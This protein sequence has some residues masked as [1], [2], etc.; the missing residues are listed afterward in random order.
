MSEPSSATPDGTA[1]PPK[2]QSA[3]K[4]AAEQASAEIAELAALSLPDVL[5][6][7]DSTATGLGAAD[8]A[9]RLKSVGPNRIDTAKRKHLLFAFIERLGNPL[10]AILLFAAA[11]SALT[12]DVASFV[13]IA[14]IVLISIVLDVTQERQAGNAAER[15]REE[16][17]LSVKAFRDG[18]PIDIPAAEVVPGDIVLLA[19]G[20]LVPADSRLIESRDLYVDEALLTGEPYPAEK[21]A[22]PTGGE[23]P[24]ESALPQNLVFMGSSVVSGTGK[25]LVLATGRK[26]QLGSI[27]SAL[28]KP[29][30]P[31]AFALGIQK[32]GM[33][34]V[35]ATIFLVLFV[36]LINLLFHRPLLESFLF[37]LAL[38]VGLTPELLPMIV[39][40]TLSHGALRMARKQVIVKRLSAIDDLGSMDVLCSDKTGT[41]TEAHIK[42]VREVDLHGQNSAIVMRMAQINAAFET[43][44]KSPLDEAILAAGQIDLMAW[45]KIDEVPFDFERRRVSVLVEGGGRRLIVVKGAPE[46]VL[47]LAASYDKQGSSPVPL[48]AAARATAEATFKALS[49]EGYR[50]LGVAWRDV[51]P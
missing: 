20:D 1:L 24:R 42:L 29:S 31:T 9:A 6:K 39:S 11:V 14:V 18:R 33:M 28:Q 32:F 12:G 38:A 17:S 41:L 47:G 3:S 23:V 2:G 27:A 36:L 8:A 45:R 46:D 5:Q 10:V 21:E 15:L 49:S 34:I 44:L 16:V 51:Q 37:A 43:G 13:V 30:P 35:Q 4:G 25:A 22:V 40:V 7:L 48:D 26:A 50:I 19:A